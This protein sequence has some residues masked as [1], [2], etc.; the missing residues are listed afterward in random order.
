MKL[1]HF[2][3]L[4]LLLTACS[5]YRYDGRAMEPTIKHGDLIDADLSAYDKAD[6]KRW[7]IVV[8]ESPTGEGDWVSRVVGL[9]GETIDVAF[10]QV[11]INGEAQTPPDSDLR[12]VKDLSSKIA[13]PYVIPKDSY[14][15]LGDNNSEALDSREF[16]ATPRAKIKGKVR[17][18]NINP[19]E[20][21]ILEESGQ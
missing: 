20:K 6:P 13:M 21:K 9:P 19:I 18:L 14:F 10:G 1:R 8:Y 7:D 12:Y 3:V 16:G 11:T 2:L 5:D 17:G 15:L 4:A